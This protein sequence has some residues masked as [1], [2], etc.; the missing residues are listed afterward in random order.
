MSAPEM[1]I[2]G[3]LRK[4]HGIRGE[5]IVE[6]ITD[7]PAEVFSAGRRVFLGTVDGELDPAGR[8]FEI[9]SARSFKDERLI[10]HFAGIADRTAAERW[11][12]RYLLLPAAELPP[13]AEGEVYYHE[14]IGMRVELADGRAIGDVV[15]FF[16]LPQGIALEVSHEGRT[17]MIPLRSEFVE[18]IDRRERRIVAHPPAGLLE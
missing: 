18:R 10:V 14:L 5:I 1:I 15:E 12:D 17:V 7:A 8:I 4:A 2:V 16:E 13:P 11:P 3:R 6:P 9:A